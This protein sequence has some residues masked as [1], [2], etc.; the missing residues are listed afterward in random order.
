MA[1]TDR[2][3]VMEGWETCGCSVTA[4]SVKGVTPNVLVGMGTTEYA[5]AKLIAE[6]Q[7]ARTVGLTI[8]SWHELLISR[9]SEIGKGAL[10]ERKIKGSQS[11]ILPYY[12]RR[13]KANISD[14]Y[15]T[16][17]SSTATPNAGTGGIHPGSRDLTI[18][19]PESKY[20]T[21]ELPNIS[22]YFLPDTYIYVSHAD[23]GVPGAN[24]SYKV[25]FK[26]TASEPA[27]NASDGSSQA[28]VTVVPNYSP[29]DWGD[30]TPEEKEPFEPTDGLVEV[31]VNN[32]HDREAWCHNLPSN[33]NGSIVVDWVQTF[34]HSTC[35]TDEFDRI[36]TAYAKGE[37]N[38][39]QANWG[40]AQDI[41]D[42]NKQQLEKS[43]KNFYN[44]VWYND[45]IDQAQNDPNLYEQLP[46]VV[47]PD[48]LDS[49]CEY[50]YKANA[51]GI[52][53]QLR[54]AA[55][56][57]D[58]LGGDLSLDF[59]IQVANDLKEVRAVD[60][61]GDTSVVDIF[62]DEFTGRTLGLSLRQYIRQLYGFREIR[63]FEEGTVNDETGQ[64][65]FRFTKFYI[66]GFNLT[67]A[68]FVSNFFTRRLD[69]LPGRLKNTGRGLYL[70]DWSDIT[71]GVVE[72]NSAS[73]NY[74]DKDFGN[75]NALYSCVITPNTK[76]IKL[77]SK[78][79]SIELGD[80]KRSAIIENFNANCPTWTPVPCALGYT[81]EPADELD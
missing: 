17:V 14:N 11:L 25:T 27:A 66:P 69:I 24:V 57:F 2:I 33:N 73:Y 4:L 47:D 62:T 9:V 53:T 6:A 79:F 38:V 21:R 72:T 63:T 77:W 39:F 19:L 41:A 46:K 44:A 40:R 36:A 37:V 45:V 3:N 29:A 64:P 32:I 18:G 60:T 7:F 12:Y 70:V 34:R 31:G 26:V 20:I 61:G 35:H 10:A 71:V 74:K 1:I 68:I 51:L 80:P 43:N 56:V 15:F 48:P 81:P 30:L 28:K 50:A 78:T 75:V 16:V 8:D 49:E 23:D 58:L 5:K 52:H 76:R 13:R 22:R 65:K 54:R 67:L 55:Q 42:I 59:L